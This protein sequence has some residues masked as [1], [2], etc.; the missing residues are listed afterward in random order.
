VVAIVDPLAAFAAPGLRQ[1]PDGLVIPYGFGL[2]ADP[3][4]QRADLEERYV[5]LEHGGPPKKRLEPIV[6]RGPM[7]GPSIGDLQGRFPA[8]RGF[9]RPSIEGMQVGNAIFMDLLTPA[10]STIRQG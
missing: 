3:L 2:A 6:T 1:D 4:R 9:R 8:S 7:T 5:N 10:E